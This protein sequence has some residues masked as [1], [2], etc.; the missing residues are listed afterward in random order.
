MPKES[1]NIE[2][3][4]W[5]NYLRNVVVKGKLVVCE[6]SIYS[7]D[8][9]IGYRELV[10]GVGEPIFYLISNKDSPSVTTSKHITL[11]R[12]ALHQHNHYIREWNDR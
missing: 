10:D 3:L 7:Y 5:A 9:K 6:D 4:R 11:V 8:M 12:N 1:F 2:L